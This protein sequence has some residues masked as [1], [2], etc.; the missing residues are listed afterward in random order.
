MYESIHKNN[1][2]TEQVVFIYSGIYM[3]TT[4]ITEKKEAMNSKESKKRYMGRFEEEKRK[5]K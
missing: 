4:T 2:Q 5:E 3:Y 1:I